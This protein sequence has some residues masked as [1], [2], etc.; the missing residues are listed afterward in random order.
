MVSRRITDGSEGPA[1]GNAQIFY[2]GVRQDER[3]KEWDKK[4]SAT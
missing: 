4:P 2:F 1:P 3:K